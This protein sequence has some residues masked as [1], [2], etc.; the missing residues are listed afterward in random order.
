[1]QLRITSGVLKGLRVDVPDTGLRPTAEK[2]RSALFN[3]LFAMISFEEKVFADLFAGSGA[4]G[5]EALSREF[6]RVVFADNSNISCGVIKANLEKLKL[7]QRARVIRKDITKTDIHGILNEPCDV[8]FMD[9]P[10]NFLDKLPELIN[11]L[12]AGGIMASD[13]II[14]AESSSPLDFAPAGWEKKEKNYGGTYL[15]FYR[16]KDE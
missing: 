10:Y 8:V 9:P 12:I 14:I 13:G 11:T 4:V 7:G 1:M 6:G 15:T 3:T 16:K 2:V 5:I